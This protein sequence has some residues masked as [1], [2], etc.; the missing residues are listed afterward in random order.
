MKPSR[1]SGRRFQMP[2]D[3]PQV[4]CL[5][6]KGSGM[7]LG[8]SW[9]PFHKVPPEVMVNAVFGI[10]PHKFA[11]KFHGHYLT[12]VQLGCQTALTHAAPMHLIKRT[13]N[14]YH[15][16]ESHREDLLIS[17]RLLGGITQDRAVSFSYQGTR[18]TCTPG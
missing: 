8:Q 13:E 4:G 1:R 6:S 2:F 17:K 12:I 18:K 5:T 11:H 7:N 15:K 16:C 10:D 9:K 3:Y 14:R